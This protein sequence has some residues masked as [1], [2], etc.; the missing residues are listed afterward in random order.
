MAALG[1][2]D[3]DREGVAAAATASVNGIIAIATTTITNNSSSSGAGKGRRKAEGWPR[4]LWQS[5]E[6]FLNGFQS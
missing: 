1:G 3:C 5:N 2:L 6:V 4:F